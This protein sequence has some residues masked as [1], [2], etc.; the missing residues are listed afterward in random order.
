MT[1]EIQIFK[2]SAIIYTIIERAV[3]A[4]ALIPLLT[5]ATWSLPVDLCAATIWKRL[6]C[7]PA[8][9]QVAGTAFTVALA[10]LSHQPPGTLAHRHRKRR[11]PAT[12]HRER[13]LQTRN[14]LSRTEHA[15][16]SWFPKDS[17]D[18]SLR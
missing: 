7:D 16:Q 14:C 8:S 2:C 17:C 3:A 6:V 9:R 1:R 5:C 11:L 4:A 13:M 12:C 10:W 15:G 18:P